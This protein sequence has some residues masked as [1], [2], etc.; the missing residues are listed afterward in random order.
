M[1]NFNLE[2]S[3]YEGFENNDAS[4]STSTTGG[5]SGSDTAGTTD[6]AGTTDPP[7]TTDSAD[8]TDPPATT[9]SAGTTDSA[10]TTDPPATT[11][12]ADTTDSTATTDPGPTTESDTTTTDDKDEG[13][14]ETLNIILK[15]ESLYVIFW[16]VAIYFILYSLLAFFFK[17]D[18]L[19]YVYNVIILVSILVIVLVYKF[20][21][22]NSDTKNDLHANVDQFLSFFDDKYNALYTTIGLILVYVTTWML[23]IP[24]DIDN[25]PTVISGLETLLWILL[26]LILFVV[27]FKEYMDVSLTKELKTF[28]KIEE[29]DSDEEEKT[30]DVDEETAA[31]IAAS[32]SSDPAPLDPNA[33]DPVATGVSTTNPDPTN[34]VDIT[35]TELDLKEV[36]NIGGNHYTYSDAEAIC[37]AYDAELADYEQIEGAYGRGAEWCN[38]G[39][40]KG[41][42]ALFPTQKSTWDKLQDNDNT[43]H[44]CGRPGINGGYMA[45]PALRFGVNCY[46]VKPNKRDIDYGPVT[47]GDVKSAEDKAMDAKVAFWKSQKDKLKLNHYDAT[48]WSRY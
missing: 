27:G 32:T 20:F 12:S 18:S 14:S 6:S 11:D 40:S 21:D 43:K 2:Y 33:D 16:I 28:L 29:T 7:A 15:Y 26:V 5:S 22:S 34:T 39:W 46:G 13:V 45:N 1:N 47:F 3:L 10:D 37:K 38:Y 42:M 17:P 19:G 23:K 31:L 30:E 9:D 4:S 8:T 41:Q 36:F 44:N 48:R 24:T 35:Q 25:K